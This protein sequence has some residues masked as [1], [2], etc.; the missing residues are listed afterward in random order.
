MKR[1]ILFFSSLIAIVSVLLLNKKNTDFGSI[2][3]SYSDINIIPSKLDAVCSEGCPPSCV[4]I[5]TKSQK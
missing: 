1:M 3:S 2:L 4:P 5:P